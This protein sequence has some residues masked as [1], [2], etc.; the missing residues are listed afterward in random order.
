LCF[1]D[2]INVVQLQVLY[3]EWDDKITLDCEW[4]RIRVDS[5]KKIHENFILDNR[6]A[7]FDGNKLR[8]YLTIFIYVIY[9]FAVAP[10][11]EPRAFVKSF[12]SL[13][14]LNISQPVG[15]LGR[16]ISPSQGLY[17]DKQRINTD[18]SMPL[19]RIR[20]HDASVRASEVS[21]C[22]RLRG[23]RGRVPRT[24]S[25]IEIFNNI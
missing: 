20:T 14:F 24:L 11:S 13:Q 23:H 8:H 12:V 7:V 15:L 16:R 17:Q 18:T 3:N 2:I 6:K 22:L 9:L 19:S 1:G 21:S 10:A 25:W 4:T 5:W